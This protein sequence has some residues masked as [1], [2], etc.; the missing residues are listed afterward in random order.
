MPLLAG[1]LA[2][3]L[4]SALIHLNPDPGELEGLPNLVLGPLALAPPRTLSGDSPHYLVAINSLI[5]D[6]D[7]DLAN[8]YR[9]ALLSD[10][11]AGARHRAVPL[12]HHAETDRLGRE[13]GTHSPFFALALAVFLWPL[14]GT[15]WVEPGAVILTLFVAWLG[16]VVLMQSERSG[17]SEATARILLLGLASPLWCYSR[18]LWTEPWVMTCWIVLLVSRRPS[19]VF[20][21]GLLG[22]LF[23]YPFA[24]VPIGFALAEFLSVR[25]GSDDGGPA[26]RKL[27]W[28]HLA[29]A[30]VGL[31]SIL[32]VVQLLFRESDHF[33]WFHSGI[34]SS[35]GIPGWSLLG[36]LLDPANGLLWFFPIL[37]FS[38]VNIRSSPPRQ[39][40]PFLAFFLVHAA[41]QDWGGGTGFAARYL[42]PALPVLVGWLALR[43]RSR[44]LP[45][46]AV[47]SVF[48]GV[49]GGVLPALVFDRTPRGVIEHVFA[50]IQ[51][52]V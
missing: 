44:W 27:I 39:W 49:L 29:G 12:V 37:L 5:E 47:W 34:H 21:F 43:T 22:T 10:W 36:L 24:V 18:D 26:H 28:A 51:E 31:V 30:A 1:I 16:L 19:L 8:N 6:G 3:Y 40:V 32:G 35:F 9:Q 45:P 48:W 11:D 23:K 17:N 52:W 42:V 15:S 41:Y 33:S 4:G 38:L 25:Q 7:F 46:V 2:L 50:K 14:A 13:R 20:L